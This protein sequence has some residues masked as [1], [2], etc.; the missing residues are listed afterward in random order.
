M[1]KKKP[2]QILGFNFVC[3]CIWLPFHYSCV[4]AYRLWVTNTE[5]SNIKPKLFYS[6]TLLNTS[7][8]CPLVD[9]VAHCFM[10]AHFIHT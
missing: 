8:F 10:F 6:A 1:C 9:S 2:A 7:V 4:I 3:Q 5:R